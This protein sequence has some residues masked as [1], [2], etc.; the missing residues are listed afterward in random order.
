MSS[1]RWARSLDIVGKNIA[2]SSHRSPQPCNETQVAGRTSVV[3]SPPTRTERLSEPVIRPR[4][5]LSP[6]RS[7]ST[8]DSPRSS[9]SLHA[10]SLSPSP[11]SSG[12]ISP[13]FGISGKQVA[14]LPSASVIGARLDSLL[15]GGNAA[16]EDRTAASDSHQPRCLAK[17]RLLLPRLPSNSSTFGETRLSSRLS[18]E[19]MRST[20]V[21]SRASSASL[22]SGDQIL[23]PML[24]GGPRRKSAPDFG[25]RKGRL[26]D[27][28][29][30]AMHGEQAPDPKPP[31]GYAGGPRFPRRRS[32]K[33]VFGEP[34]EETLA[35]ENT[36]LIRPVAP[37]K[38]IRTPTSNRPS[39]RLSDHDTFVIQ[40]SGVL[41]D[42]DMPFTCGTKFET[43]QELESLCTTKLHEM[44]SLGKRAMFICNSTQHSRQTYLEELTKKGIDICRGQSV[45]ARPEAED[46]II[47]PGHTCAWFLRASGARKPFLLSPQ[48]G[49]LKDLK[50]DGTLDV[51][52]TSDYAKEAGATRM[53]EAMN[54]TVGTDA[55]VVDWD[56]EPTSIQLAVAAKHLSDQKMPLVT[57]CSPHSSK[58]LKALWNGA[59]VRSLTGFHDG[60]EIDVEA[61][62][63][64]MRWPSPAALNALAAPKGSGGYGV[65]LDEAVFV[66]NNLDEIEC[67]KQS[68]MFCAF[69][70]GSVMSRVQLLQFRQQGRAV[71]DWVIPSFAD[72]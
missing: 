68:G 1:A 24:E 47:S 30:V 21:A 7:F 48:R 29:V 42:V 14:S 59:W 72:A 12:A 5:S 44:L 18:I 8:C 57:C 50:A 26:D 9:L 56:K 58:K 28:P 55:V 11:R 65:D 15:T 27:R 38:L 54:S 6:R 69:I 20:E 66:S 16:D 45:A 2:E 17:D 22:D 35:D 37:L 60:V 34:V 49:L 63:T 10:G 31:V 40:G 32:S 64:S 4:A 33:L 41:W 19:S 70:M 62:G 46:S 52:D 25:S 13:E 51:P 23:E 36:D 71:P 3:K 61:K 43:I 39:K 53:S 67:A